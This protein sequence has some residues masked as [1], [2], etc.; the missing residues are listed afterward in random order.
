MNDMF[1]RTLIITPHLDDETIGAGGTMHRIISNGG[2]VKV[3]VVGTPVSLYAPHRG[4]YTDVNE[5][6]QSLR[7]AMDTLGVDNIKYLEGYPD[8]TMH[9]VPIG[10]L[11]N[12]L[13][14]IIYDFEPTAVLFPYPSHHQD[15]KYVSEATVASLRPRVSINFVKLKAMYE[16]PY[17][18]GFNQIMLPTS[19]LYVDLDEEDVKCKMKALSCYDSQL[20]RDPNDILDKSAI[21]DLL[22]VRGREVGVSYA[23]VFYPL[24]ISVR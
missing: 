22:R 4:E 14:N 19:K 11:I 15:H 9:T 13:D 21:R 5:R 23:E 8:T 1:D 18:T 20:D 2:M 10:R 24:S 17:V 7:K 3:V 6:Y 16:Y 12:E